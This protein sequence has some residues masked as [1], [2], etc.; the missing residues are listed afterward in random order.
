MA[1]AAVGPMHD[2]AIN[3]YQPVLVDSAPVDEE[4]PCEVS[5][6][7]T[8]ALLYHAESQYLLHWH[9]GRFAPWPLA[10]FATTRF[11]KSTPT[12]VGAAG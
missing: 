12:A 5:F 3:P 8:Y 4:L 7:L 1:L 2:R 9:P 6:R 11:T 10:V